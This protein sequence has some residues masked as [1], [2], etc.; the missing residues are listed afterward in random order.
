MPPLRPAT[1]TRLDPAAPPLWRD[2]DTLQFG[3]DGSLTVTAD[4]PWIEPLI[5]RMAAGFRLRSF[6]VLAHAVGAPRDDARALLTRLRPLLV[7]DG[8]GGGSA[9]VDAID[10]AD[11]RCEYRMR[12]ALADE[13]VHL[14]DRSDRS[15]CGVVLLPG[16]A[17]ALQFARYLR[18]DIVHL[19]VALE[20]GRT[21]VGPVIVPGSTPCLSCR[22]GH[23]RDRDAAWPRLHAQLIG[24]D[25]GALSAAR[26]AEAAALAA[27]VLRSED[28]GAFVEV[29]DR[30]D[31][32]WRRVTFH[33]GCRCRESWSRSPRGSATAPVPLA[34]PTS[35][36]TPP[37]Y[38]R[39]A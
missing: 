31:R 25:P 36:T 23:A 14:A 2:G 18:D 22:D 15:A 30:G 34:R 12:E 35:T 16:A 38:A 1:I 7:E 17:A 39:P 13:G 37:A 21:T 28:A 24:R 5:A 9:W 27:A 29:N 26:I 6:D 8:G 20:R 11:G 10:L 3:L 19:P 4:A 33:A 32:V